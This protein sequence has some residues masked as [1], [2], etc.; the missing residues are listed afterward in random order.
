[1]GPSLDTKVLSEYDK[2][3]KDYVGIPNTAMAKAKLGEVRSVL[4]PTVFE[5]RY[6]GIAARYNLY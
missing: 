3:I 1:M 4:G 6:P 5:N 2:V